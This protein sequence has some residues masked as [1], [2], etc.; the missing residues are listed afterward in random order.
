M[1]CRLLAA[2]LQ[3]IHQNRTAG[4]RILLVIGRH[5]DFVASCGYG[6][7]DASLGGVSLFQLFRAALVA[8]GRVGCRQVLVVLESQ[9]KVGAASGGG[10][11]GLIR[12]RE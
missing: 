4:L 1:A 6:W 2:C 12:V 7:S 9:D 8:L 11:P 5:G 3:V 10:C